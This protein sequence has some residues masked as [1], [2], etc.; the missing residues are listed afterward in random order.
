MIAVAGATLKGQMSFES[1]P[2]GHQCSR[3]WYHIGR[4]YVYIIE[5]GAASVNGFRAV[6]LL[7]GR[8]SHGFYLFRTRKE[9]P[10][11]APPCTCR[12]K[13]K[14]VCAAA[15]S[16][17]SHPIAG[18]PGPW[19]D[20][21]RPEKGIRPRRESTGHEQRARTVSDPAERIHKS[22]DALRAVSFQAKELCQS[23]ATGDAVR[24]L[25]PLIPLAS[26]APGN[27][28]EW[29]EVLVVPHGAD[30]GGGATGRVT[31]TRRRQFP[32]RLE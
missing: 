3:L 16:G 25:T 7:L 15:P 14:A 28:D 13:V 10:S 27:H 1:I 9:L 31:H 4:R 6:F 24:G 21:P 29:R 23:L 5:T 26:C 20:D 11:D 22:G 17:C 32:H 2:M 12:Q 8:Y 30:T 19:R 18:A